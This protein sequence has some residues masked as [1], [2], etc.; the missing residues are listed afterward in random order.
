MLADGEPIPDKAPME[1]H[2][3]DPAYAGGTWALV[4][5][6]LSRLSGEVR[7]INVSFPERILAMVDQAAQQ[8]GESRSGFLAHAALEYLGHHT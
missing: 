1:A 5:I 2:Q 3:N 7:R 4:E 6:D 8:E